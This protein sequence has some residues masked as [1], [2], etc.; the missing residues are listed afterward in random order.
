MAAPGTV[1][2]D[3]R[4]RIFVDPAAYANPVEWQQ[5]ASEIRRES[6]VLR[7]EADGFPPFWAI[8]RHADVMS[9]SQQ[10][11]LFLNTMDSVLL[12]TEVMER[13]RAR[14]VDLKTLIHM[15]GAEHM[16]YRKL[17]TDWFKPAALRSIQATIDELA[18]RFVDRLANFPGSV[19][20]ATD[21]VMPFPLH[22][23]MSTLGIPEEDEP[24]MLK[25]TQE[26]FGSEDPEYSTNP[27]ERDAALMATLL[28]FGAYFDSL[29]KDRRAHPGADL[30]SVI[31][32]GVINDQ[33]IG[34]LETMGYYVIIATAGHDT[35]AGS[36][37]GGVEQLLR[38]PDQLE[39][40]RDDPELIPNAVEEIIRWSSPVRHFL[41][42]ATVDT[43][44]RGT[45]IAAGDGLLLS[46]LSANFDEDVFE[47]PMWFDVTRPNAKDH[48]AFGWG[49]HHC[50]GSQLARMELRAF[51]REFSSRVEV[52]EIAG[53]PAWAHTTFVGGIKHLPVTYR[54][55]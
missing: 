6:P 37:S 23:I 19:D 31:A 17:T 39:A 46:Y 42:Y 40:L 28:E 26:I 48:I 3:P 43:E 8:T 35:T 18:A 32:N 11:D 5:V 25:L 2:S 36:V 14:G 41:R 21:I 10:N 9:I 13:N 38:H 47:E 52:M 7:V 54:L 22:V 12:P 51:L 27:E 49:R 53:E 30:A 29:I 24:R 34:D 44:I 4:G 1:T 45:P 16:A 55:R 20:L 15:D 33:Q 50:L